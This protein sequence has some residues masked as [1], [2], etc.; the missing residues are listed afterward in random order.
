M[1]QRERISRAITL[2]VLGRINVGRLTITDD[3]GT[4]VCGPGGG[5]GTAPG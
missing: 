4:M 3:N 5:P 1:N 2:N